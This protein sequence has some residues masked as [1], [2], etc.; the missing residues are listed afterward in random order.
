[1]KNIFAM[2]VRTHFRLHLDRRGM[3]VSEHSSMILIF[4]FETRLKGRF[5]LKS[6]VCPLQTENSPPGG[7]LTY[8]ILYISSSPYRALC[9]DLNDEKHDYATQ[10]TQYRGTVITNI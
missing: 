3:Q 4:W 10:R 8:N 5:A 1:M 6:A 7:Q 9:T 2:Y